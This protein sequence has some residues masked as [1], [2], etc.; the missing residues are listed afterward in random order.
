MRINRDST[1]QDMVTAANSLPYAVVEEC[2]DAL[3]KVARH[4]DDEGDLLPVVLLAVAASRV[5]QT[6]TDGTP[7]PCHPLSPMAAARVAVMGAERDRSR[8]AP[9]AVIGSGWDD[10]DRVPTSPSAEDVALGTDGGERPTLTLGDVLPSLPVGSQSVLLGLARESGQ[11]RSVWRKVSNGERLPLRVASIARS[12]GMPV[13]RDKRQSNML[14]ALACKSWAQAAVAMGYAT[15]VRARTAAALEYVTAPPRRPQSRMSHPVN[16]GS[17]WVKGEPNGIPFTASQDGMPVRALSYRPV[18]PT[19]WA[20]NPRPTDGVFEGLTYGQGSV[21]LPD[22]EQLPVILARRFAREQGRQDI[23]RE[24]RERS[25]RTPVPVRLPSKAGD[26]ARGSGSALAMGARPDRL[27]CRRP[28]ATVSDSPLA[29]RFATCGCGARPRGTALL[30]G[31]HPLTPC[32]R[33]NVDRCGCGRKRGAL[34][35]QAGLPVH[36]PR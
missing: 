8:R 34:L 31:E 16:I 14:R 10:G 19:K 36:A 21:G 30:A 3:G 25:D 22:R 33:P 7:L 11:S 26:S 29:E 20:P 5:P 23:A 13:P 6:S 1:V 12:L 27:L 24:S 18:A 35:W 28:I 32:E 2:I 4:A 17:V 15:D 9:T